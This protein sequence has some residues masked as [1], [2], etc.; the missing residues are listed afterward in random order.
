MAITL[1]GHQPIDFTYSEN[2]S[3]E[4]LSDMCLQYETADNPMFQIK[5]SDTSVPLVTIQG[6]GETDFDIISLTPISQTTTGYYTFQLDFEAL[7]ITE[8]C[9]ELCV[10]EGAQS[11]GNLVTNGTFGSSLTGWTVANGLQLD[12][13]NTTNPTNSITCDGQVDLV[14]TG[15]T[16]PYQYSNNGTTYQVSDIFTGLCYNTAY[17][18]Y[19]KDT[20]GV[21]DS[22]QFQFRDCSTFAG[23]EAFEI[24]DIK[25]FEIKNCEAFDFA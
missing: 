6:T 23:S 7:G 25:A 17:T 13:D 22:I 10:Y 12:M 1:L 2:G 21:V 8:G 18:F 16:A 14:A 19:V 11:S 9:F 3:C 15:G 5:A 20:Y 4:N 24:K